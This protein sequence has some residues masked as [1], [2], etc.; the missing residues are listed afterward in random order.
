MGSGNEARVILFRQVFNHG[1]SDLYRLVLVQKAGACKICDCYVVSSEWMV[2]DR[3]E[4]RQ[5]V[6]G[7][8]AWR[9]D[10]ENV[11]NYDQRSDNLN[12]RVC[13]CGETGIPVVELMLVQEQDKTVSLLLEPRELGCPAIGQAVQT[14]DE[15]CDCWPIRSWYSRIC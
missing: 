7:G 11:S 14:D 8:I 6:L 2:S 1:W 9:Q 13:E 15:Y 3:Y 5:S 10:C 4:S 12:W